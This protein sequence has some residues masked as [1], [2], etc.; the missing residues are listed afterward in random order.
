MSRL[1]D[2]AMTYLSRITMRKTMMEDDVKGELKNLEVRILGYRNKIDGHL[3]K[4][5][6]IQQEIDTYR[7]EITTLKTINTQLEQSFKETSHK[8]DEQMELSR[9]LD[10]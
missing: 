10:V 6:A 3:E 7:K 1:N 2:S 8:Y 4:N 5:K 9:K